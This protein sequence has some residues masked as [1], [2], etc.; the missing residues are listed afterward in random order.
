MTDTQELKQ[1]LRSKIAEKL[2]HTNYLHAV[3]GKLVFQDQGGVP[4]A[5]P[6]WTSSVDAAYTLY[7]ELQFSISVGVWGPERCKQTIRIFETA[8][9]GESDDIEH[10]YERWVTENTP[11]TLAWT[12]AEAWLA[13]QGARE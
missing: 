8:T 12:M 10:K 5:E 3:D 13:Y 1:E 11:A 6:D 2:G 9:D 7:A 4:Y